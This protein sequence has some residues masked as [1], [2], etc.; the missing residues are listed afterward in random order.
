MV[1]VILCRPYRSCRLDPGNDRNQSLPVRG[2][3]RKCKC[4]HWDFAWR[5]VFERRSQVAW[6]VARTK[7]LLGI[8]RF[9]S[10]Q[11]SRL[12]LFVF[13]DDDCDAFVNLNFTAVHYGTESL[14]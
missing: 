11:E 6:K 12:A 5:S 10:A 2:F 8:E 9:D 4:Y 1:V 14:N 13:P 7:A 3:Q